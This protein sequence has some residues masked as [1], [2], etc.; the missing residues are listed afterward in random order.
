[1]VRSLEEEPNGSQQH[2]GG[3][4]LPPGWRAFEVEYEGALW[5]AYLHESGETSWDHPGRPV[6]H[7]ETQQVPAK[8]QNAPP[9]TAATRP[10]PEVTPT[11]AGGLPLPPGWHAYEVE[12]D[13]EPPL[14]AYYHDSGETRWEHPGRPAASSSSS[15]TAAPKKPRTPVSRLRKE[16]FEGLPEYVDINCQYEGELVCLL[17]KARSQS[18]PMM[19]Q[20]LECAKHNRAAALRGYHTLTWN[21]ELN[22]ME[23]ADTG[24]P[25]SRS[26]DGVVLPEAAA[27]RQPGQGRSGSRSRSHAGL[28]GERVPGSLPEPA[29][30]WLVLPSSEDPWGRWAEAAAD[31][32]ASEPATRKPVKASSMSRAEKTIAREPDA[33]PTPCYDR[34]RAEGLRIELFMESWPSG[35]SA[36]FVETPENEWG[37][38]IVFSAASARVCWRMST[39]RAEPPPLHGEAVPTVCTGPQ[40]RPPQRPSPAAEAEVSVPQETAVPERERAPCT[41][42]ESG[43]HRWEH[44]APVP[45][46]ACQSFHQK[47]ASSISTLHDDLPSASSRRTLV[48]TKSVDAASSARELGYAPENFISVEPGEE[49]TVLL[50]E[51]GWYYGKSSSGEGWLPESAAS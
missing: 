3:L 35:P 18:V 42:D 2:A 28:G 29:P 25:V 48:A 43:E 50:E 34:N 33:E 15:S 13:G 5:P 26:T 7:P 9:A 22:R 23:H 14:T 30:A 8:R 6:P 17:C 12:Q 38:R 24:Q 16:E 41:H 20:H 36:W 31:A 1:M 32:C 37:Q 46:E 19:Y 44:P 45:E 21:R 39:V 11:P 10:Q 47:Q 4:P 51:D 40:Q 27:Q 49:V